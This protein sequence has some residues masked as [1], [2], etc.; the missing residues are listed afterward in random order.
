M[1]TF[2]TCPPLSAFDGEEQVEAFA[3]KIAQAVADAA[4]RRRAQFTFH[5]K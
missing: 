1:S 4:R 5:S 2:D 3:R